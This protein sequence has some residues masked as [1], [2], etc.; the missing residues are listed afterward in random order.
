MREGVKAACEYFQ[1][2]IVAR[3]RKGWHYW[4]RKG[5]KTQAPSFGFLSTNI[6]ICVQVKSNLEASAQVGPSKAESYKTSTCGSR[7]RR[8]TT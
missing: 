4:E 3:V 6:L 5:S 1:E 2:E 8:R 7:P